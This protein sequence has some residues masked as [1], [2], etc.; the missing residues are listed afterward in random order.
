MLTRILAVLGVGVWCIFI[1]LVWLL[2]PIVALA[3]HLGP[4]QE[5]QTLDDVAAILA[6]VKQHAAREKSSPRAGS[7]NHSVPRSACIVT[8]MRSISV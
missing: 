2:I 4:G 7:N 3:Y 6:D 1:L 8:A 5:R